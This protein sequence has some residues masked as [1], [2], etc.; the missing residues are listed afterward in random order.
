MQNESS[1]GRT[2]LIFALEF[3]V[4]CLFINLRGTVGWT[5]AIIITHHRPQTV[6]EIS[7]PPSGCSKIFK[8]ENTIKCKILHSL[9]LVIILPW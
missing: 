3:T 9:I 2:V 4:N 6:G 1:D 5:I 7:F 8:T